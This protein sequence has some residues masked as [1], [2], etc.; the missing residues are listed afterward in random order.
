MNG[1]TSIPVL[2]PRAMV[3]TN[4]I[5]TPVI[6]YALV[7]EMI[8]WLAQIGPKHSLVRLYLNHNG[9]HPRSYSSRWRDLHSGFT[10]FISTM[11]DMLSLFPG[12]GQFVG[13]F[14]V[15][16]VAQAR[17]SSGDISGDY[18]VT[19]TLDNRQQMTL[20]LPRP[21]AKLPQAFIFDWLEVENEFSTRML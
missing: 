13:T 21:V 2:V 8:G 7:E 9:Q 18:L 1:V 12:P 17:T 16:E 19:I 4:N 6:F 10:T 11:R 20:L 5:Q 14:G 3:G 15:I